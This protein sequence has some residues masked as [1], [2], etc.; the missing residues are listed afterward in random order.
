VLI[1]AETI[2]RV[3]FALNAFAL[4]LIIPFCITLLFYGMSESSEQGGVI[5]KPFFTVSGYCLIYIITIVVI[6]LKQK[7]N[8]PLRAV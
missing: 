3:L 7:E 1:Q 5:L 8:R 2:K 6:Y 4:A